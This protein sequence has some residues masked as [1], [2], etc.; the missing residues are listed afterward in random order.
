MYNL[1]LLFYTL[2]YSGCLGLE[3]NM[4]DLSFTKEE[5]KTCVN[6]YL[7]YTNCYGYDWEGEYLYCTFSKNQ[8]PSLDE[9]SAVGYIYCGGNYFSDACMYGYYDYFS[10]GYDDGYYFTYFVVRTEGNATA[11]IIVIVVIVV[12]ICLCIGCCCYCCNKKKRANSVK[13]NISNTDVKPIPMTD[14]PSVVQGYQIL[15]VNID[16]A[17]ANQS[18][19]V[20]A[21]QIPINNTNSIVT[22]QAGTSYYVIQS[23]DGGIQYVP[24]QSV[25]IP[26]QFTSPLSEEPTFDPPNKIQ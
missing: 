16:P 25:Q 10:C 21:Y 17:M 8:H 20:Q 5:G 26:Q 3:I 23:P 2:L 7:Y 9:Y 15:T 18:G 22:D 24:V 6:G 1:I 13:K 4:N 12:L 14:Q 11:L 19:I